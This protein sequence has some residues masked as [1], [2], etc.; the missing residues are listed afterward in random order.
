[1]PLMR[2][3][4]AFVLVLIGLASFLFVDYIMGIFFFTLGIVLAATEG[5]EINLESKTFREI[6]SVFGLHFGKWKPCP[7]F[8]YLSFFKTKET[9]EVKSMGA[10]MGSFKTDIIHLNLF[11]NKNKHITFY[12]TDDK[13]DAFEVAEHFKL[14][15]DIDILN[16]TESE[17][18]WL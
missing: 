16:A 9:T 10:I 1:M 12:E 7:E 18:V 4:L 2:K 11:Y 3:V 15:F 13:K 17:S 14:V 8:E 5:S 6:K